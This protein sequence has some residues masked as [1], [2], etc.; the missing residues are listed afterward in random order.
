M[1]LALIP[2][3]I[4]MAFIHVVLLYGTNNVQTVG[5]H[6]SATDLEHRSIGARLVLAAR[7]FYAMFIWISKLTVSEFLKRITIRIWRRSYELTLQGIRIFLLLTFIAVVIA[8]LCECDP[9]DHY[10]QVVPDPGPHCRQ[11]YGN[12]ITMGVCDIITDILL[13]AFPIPIILNSG[14]NWKRKF[15]LVSLF[16]LS[17]ILIIVTALRVPKVIG[18]RGRQ[19]YRTVWASAEILA[20]AAVSNTVIIGSFLRDKGTKKNKF[21]SHSVSDSIERS[22]VR[23]PTVTALQNTGSDED[24]FRFLGIRVPDHLQ[25]EPEA[26]RAP[27]T[28]PPDPASRHPSKVKEEDE[29]EDLESGRPRNSEQNS[30]DS[31][32]SLQKPPVVEHHAPSPVP[33][34]QRA[35]SFQDVGGLLDDGSNTPESRSRS[36]TIHSNGGAIYAQDFAASTPSPT[37]SRRGSRA[38]EPAYNT[39]P[40][41]SRRNSRSHGLQDIGGLL[42]PTTSRASSGMD[43]YY[44]RRQSDSHI[45]P[46]ARHMRPAPAGILGPMLERRE[47]QQSLQDPGGLLSSITEGQPGTLRPI[48]SGGSS[49][50][51]PVPR[52]ANPIDNIELDDIGGLLAPDHQPDASAAALERATAR[53]QRSSAPQAAPAPRASSSTA[54]QHQAGW[55]SL[56]IPDPGG[57]L[58]R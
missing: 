40:S 6:Y 38:Y 52:T 4:R 33:S 8:T 32:D 55:D 39:T 34:S 57:L 45:H 21:R 41:Q 22:S 24:L 16:S 27:P 51:S 20:S 53:A 19:Q 37:Q 17:I 56:D 5:I 50:G 49:N 23:R 11:G 26:P 7:I 2:L 28:V 46:P 42:T 54:E 47:T 31:D 29:P 48:L 43:R 9:F 12:L 10:W 25:D 3:V 58:G 44:G 14:Q 1:M 35:A 36:T 30:S 18:Y 13:I 15:Q